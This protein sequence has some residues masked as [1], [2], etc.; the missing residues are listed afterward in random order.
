MKALFVGLGSIG[1]RHLANLDSLCKREGI[2]LEVTAL[3]SSDR[4]LPDEL[5]RMVD[6][7][8]K[9]L[10][11]GIFYDL[12]FITVP[13]H[14]HATTI[15]LLQGRIGAFFIEKPLFEST[16]FDL[17][18]IGLEECKKAYVAA[19]MRWC[20]LFGALKK[21]LEGYQPYSVRA[22]C[23]SYLPD[24]RPQADYR[25]IY[26]ARQDMGGG[27]SLDLIHEWDYLV[28]LFG[29][30]ETS[31]QLRGHYSDLEIDSDDLSIY[32][33]RYPGF[34]TELH[35]DY[36]GRQYRRELEIFTR[37]GSLLANFAT[38][39]LTLP[40][41]TIEDYSE[42]LNRRYEREMAYFVR[43][44]QSQQCESLNSPRHAIQVLKLALGEKWNG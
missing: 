31:F 18:A 44:S 4:P 41:G 16:D 5:K 42:P 11:P 36:F 38:G 39:Q 2:S 33:A 23:S 27:V 8:V 3:R 37:E 43:Y 28:N 6:K 21:K 19:P 13:T 22:I 34:L 17:D 29:M 26:S 12:A 1:T 40:D 20:A 15:G 9:H 35:L 30:P 10:E 32:I 24:W 14:L 25:D 7:E